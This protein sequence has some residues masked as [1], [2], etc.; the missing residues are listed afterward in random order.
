MVRLGT[1]GRLHGVVA[2]AG[3]IGDGD[4]GG[5]CQERGGINS[6]F[7]IIQEDAEMGSLSRCLCLECM[8]I[9]MVG[10]CEKL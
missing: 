1:L 10:R 6:V 4:G 2:K 5:D 7:R 9:D 3:G 8:Y